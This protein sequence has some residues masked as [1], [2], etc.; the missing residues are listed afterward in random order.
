M[1]RIKHCRVISVSAVDAMQQHNY[2]FTLKYSAVKRVVM[3]VLVSLSHVSIKWATINLRNGMKQ[4]HHTIYVMNGPGGGGG[5][6]Y[7]STA[8]P[9]QVIKLFFC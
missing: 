9:S 6:T 4:F 8:Q 5:I 7:S 1:A 2:T 3:A